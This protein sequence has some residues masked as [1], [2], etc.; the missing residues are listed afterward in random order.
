M[1]QASMHEGSRPL[2]LDQLH[3]EVPSLDGDLLQTG[4]LDSLKLIERLTCLEAQFGTHIG[5]QSLDPDNLRS[6]S[7]IA[8]L[9]HT[10]F[11]QQ[12]EEPY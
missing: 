6:I 7:R 1:T 10:H 3:I 9:L 2:F 5:M 11:A 8:E 12:G 4:L